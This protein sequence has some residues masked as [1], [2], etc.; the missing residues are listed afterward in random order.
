MDTILKNVDPAAT[1]FSKTRRA[2]LSLLYAAPGKA[3][4]LR[5]IARTAGVGLGGLQRELK[6]LTAAGVIRRTVRGRQVFYQA[7]SE[8]PIFKELKSLIIRHTEKGAVAEATLPY[9]AGSPSTGAAHRRI[10]VPR[11]KLAAFCQ[12]HYIR[13]LSLFGSVLQE[14]FRPNSD[15]DVLV[16]FEPGKTPGFAFFGIQEELS[17][18]LRRKVHL[19]TPA[20][21]SRYFRDQVVKEAQILYEEA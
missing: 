6:Q 13:K 17:K 4:Y 20:C 12:R 11:R 7:N 18:M 3:Y 5:E 8:S 16:E 19:N 1:L 10:V 9:I 21:L 2:I 14:D 15:I